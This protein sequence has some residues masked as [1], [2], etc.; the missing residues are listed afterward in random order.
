MTL[1]APRQAREMHTDV[2]QILREVGTLIGII[3]VGA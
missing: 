3:Y 1:L 2:V